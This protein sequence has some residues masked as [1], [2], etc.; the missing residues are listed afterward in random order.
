MN[1]CR[2]CGREM[3]SIEYEQGSLLEAD[4]YMKF[5]YY[6]CPVCKISCRPV[7]VA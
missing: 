2:F 6:R 1:P 4:T 7:K 5:R 3:E